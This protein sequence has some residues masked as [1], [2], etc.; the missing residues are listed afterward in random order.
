MFI[1]RFAINA[2]SCPFVILL[3]ILVMVAEKINR[4]LRTKSNASLACLAT[5][6]LVVGLVVQSLQIV[7]CSFML[8]GETGIICNR[9]D[10]IT[11]AITL[12]C[13]IASLNHFV[14]LSVERYL[15]I[16]HP[17][18]YENRVT[19]VHKPSSLKGIFLDQNKLGL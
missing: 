15:A 12:R 18:V 1:F 7:H 19:E 6:D 11:A 8:K 3:N 4:Q 16:K 13:V 5:T 2:V 14:V 17:F 10:S 9:V